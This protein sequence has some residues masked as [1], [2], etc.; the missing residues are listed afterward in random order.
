MKIF[1]ETFE[2]IDDKIVFQVRAFV[3]DENT[4]FIC[5]KNN[6]N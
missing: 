3:P 1:T 6:T 4:Y 5:K 2:K